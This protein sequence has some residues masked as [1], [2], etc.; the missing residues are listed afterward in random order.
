[1][2]WIFQRSF[3][4]GDEFGLLYDMRADEDGVREEAGEL[5]YATLSL[6]NK[7]LQPV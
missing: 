1:M 4:P 6:K 7:K 2:M 5:L 3:Q